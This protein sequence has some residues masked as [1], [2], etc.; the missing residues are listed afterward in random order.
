MNLVYPVLGSLV[1]LR[2]RP[3][4]A[5]VGRHNYFRMHTSCD[6]ALLVL[7]LR[8]WKQL[9]RQRF[10]FELF[11]WE[12]ASTPP[13]NCPWWCDWI[14]ALFSE[15]VWVHLCCS[16]WWCSTLEHSMKCPS[17]K[18]LLGNLVLDKKLVTLVWSHSH[19]HPT[20]QQNSSV[21]I[22]NLSLFLKG[23]LIFINHRGVSNKE[24]NLHH[25]V[26]HRATLFLF[27]ASQY[28]WNAY[29]T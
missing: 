1:P 24:T 21:S 15:E 18:I 20:A 6:S 11:P 19:S 12:N 25:R 27:P 13:G 9:H 22:K 26:L 4:K 14:K 8:I 2:V 17:S 3:P 16:A 29:T 7:E 10:L 23:L 5:T 28:H